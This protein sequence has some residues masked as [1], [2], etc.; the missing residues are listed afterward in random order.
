MSKKDDVTIRKIG[1]DIY[2]LEFTIDSQIA[3]EVI[4]EQ[5]FNNFEEVND[6]TLLQIL[7]RE[8]EKH[9]IKLEFRKIG[10]EGYKIII[11]G[12]KA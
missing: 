11:G 4:K 10:E 6:E 2:E 12:D 9:N 1:N 3:E 5:G 7:Q 8:L